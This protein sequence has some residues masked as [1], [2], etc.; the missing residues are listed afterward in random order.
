MLK[1]VFGKPKSVDTSS[2]L[3]TLNQLNEVFPLSLSL[4]LS[5]CVARER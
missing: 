4:S 2:T 1:K 5:L 3:T